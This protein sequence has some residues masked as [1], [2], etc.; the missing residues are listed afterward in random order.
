MNKQKQFGG[1][2]VVL[3]FLSFS[4]AC[5]G[6][7]ALLTPPPVTG[8][9]ETIV[10]STLVA[11]TASA[12]AIT[13]VPA[14]YTSIPFVTA[15]EASFGEVYVYTAVENVNLRVQPGMLFQ[16][17][18]VLVKNTRLRLLGSAPGGEWYYVRNDESISGWVN[19]N[20]VGGGYDGPP[21]PLVEPTD[22]ILVTGKV[23][24]SLGT[25]VS[26]IGFALTQGSR[27]TDASTDET[28][29]FYAY[30]PRTMSGT[31][32]VGYVSIACTS[33][34]MDSNCKCISGLCGKAN[35]E[36]ISITLPQNGVLNFVWK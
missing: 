21:A 22:V 1:L 18:R 19:V 34:T 5:S 16:V 10:A 12:P 7:V 29:Q 13:S 27:R 9:V 2:F 24:T 32:Q 8:Q 25:P 11:L 17:S 35:P 4:L 6:E 14:T 30:L 15:T 26:G 3:L 23:M 36:N 33:N 20:V 28:G 31:W